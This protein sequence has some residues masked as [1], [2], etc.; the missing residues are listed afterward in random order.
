LRSI[1]GRE[2]IRALEQAGFRV[3]R[4]RGSNIIL[5]REEPYADGVVPN[6]REVDRGT[7]RS[8]I[9]DAGLTVEEFLKLLA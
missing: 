3:R 1:S 6:H 4:Q 2:R 5:K 7:L 9:R 8:I